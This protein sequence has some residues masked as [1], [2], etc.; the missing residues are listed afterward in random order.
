MDHFSISNVIHIR[1]A[2]KG[3]EDR[4]KIVIRNK[5]ISLFKKIKETR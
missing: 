5:R 4:S 2:W 1:R 3:E